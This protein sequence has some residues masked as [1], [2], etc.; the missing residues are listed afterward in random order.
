VP[1]E[2][3]FFIKV[4]QKKD[5]SRKVQALNKA[6]TPG[7]LLTSS[8]ELA[9]RWASRETLASATTSRGDPLSRSFW[10][11]HHSSNFLERRFIS[12]SSLSRRSSGGSFLRVLIVTAKERKSKDFA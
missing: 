11:L 8:E 3:N 9:D 1:R 6:K 4:C 7:L 5:M 10:R 2:T 12:S